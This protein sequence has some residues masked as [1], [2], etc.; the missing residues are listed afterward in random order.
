MLTTGYVIDPRYIE[1]MAVMDHPERPERIATL[2]DFMKEYKRDGLKAV[3]PRPATLDEIA[4]NH[5]RRLIDMVRA[6]ADVD[7]FA[8]DYDTTTNRRTFE[9]ALLA[10]GGLLALVDRI[11]ENDVAN[12][13]AMVRPPGHHAESDRAMG[14]CFFNNIAIAARYLLQKHGLERVLIVDYD[15]HHGNGTQRSFY[16]IPEV[17]FI[18]THQYPFYPGTGA[19]GDFGVADGIGYTINLP[20]PE[21]YG[22]SEYLDGF[23]RV[24][25]PIARQFDPQFVLISAGFDHHYLDPLGGMNVTKEGIAAMTRV[26]LRIAGE[27]SGGR[28]AAVL[29]GGYD[30]GALRESVGAVLDEMGGDRLSDDVPEG[31]GADDIIAAV[32]QVHKR[33]W[34]LPAA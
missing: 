9:T 7:A 16:A 8:F 11:M 21:G 29:E 28:C 22:D 3:A 20:F 6:T 15:V 4:A 12:G 27:S 32:R 26:I 18:S 10:A 24:I 25:E 1:H 5:D 17:M 2:L 14:F 30:L 31:G 23:H 19:V 33:F 34:K 13:F